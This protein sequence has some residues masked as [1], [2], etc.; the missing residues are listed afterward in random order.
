MAK[1]KRTDAVLVRLTPADKVAI[2]KAAEGEGM[3]REEY[4]RAA[5]LTYMALTLNKHA[6]S[7]ALTGAKDMLRELEQEGKNLFFSKK[8]KA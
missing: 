8:G 5:V 2:T 1:E 4:I 7:A 6:L 3:S